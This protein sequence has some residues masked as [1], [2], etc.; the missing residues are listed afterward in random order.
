[1]GSKYVECFVP[2]KCQIVND[3]KQGKIKKLAPVINN[4]ILVYTTKERIQA[5]KSIT[6]DLQ[7]L[8]KPGAVK[9]IPIIVHEEQVQ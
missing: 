7:Y 2:M 6:E 9:N 4:L 8:T 1:M 3:K 5:L